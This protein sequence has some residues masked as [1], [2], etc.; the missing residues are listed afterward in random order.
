MAK[1]KHMKK[2]I[3]LYLFLFLILIV[4]LGALYLRLND[5]IVKEPIPKIN[6]P[7]L[8]SYSINNRIK[9]KTDKDF[10]FK[11]ILP[12]RFM[13]II[14]NKQIEVMNHNSHYLF[15]ITKNYYFKLYTYPDLDVD[16]GLYD[17]SNVGDSIFKNSN[18]LI[19]SVKRG[20]VIKN[21]NVTPYEEFWG[22]PYYNENQK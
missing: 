19:I 15:I 14:R 9:F 10:I 5:K 4:F 2:N 16:S 11:V 6:V 7:E 12:H 21:F 13:G 22:N 18:S 20:N 8:E 3:Y 1:L 17:Y